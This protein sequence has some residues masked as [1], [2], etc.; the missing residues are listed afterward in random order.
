[1][2][3]VAP[4]GAEAGVTSL[5][6]NL[7]RSKEEEKTFSTDSDHLQNLGMMI[8]AMENTLRSDMDG[9]I[10]CVADGGTMSYF[11]YFDESPFSRCISRHPMF[12]EDFIPPKLTRPS[13]RP[14]AHARFQFDRA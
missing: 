2:L 3:S 13:T 14:H 9:K 1:M 4:E 5:S 12:E 8:E 10:W 6:G 11:S 7:S